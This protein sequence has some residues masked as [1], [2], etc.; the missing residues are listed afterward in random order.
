MHTDIIT[1]VK[2]ISKA[3]VRLGKP[4]SRQCHL[5]QIYC[6]H[7][8]SP[9]GIMATVHSALHGDSARRKGLKCK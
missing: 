2:T 6:L 9:F 8:A 5:I 3:L 1:H 4:D 7:S